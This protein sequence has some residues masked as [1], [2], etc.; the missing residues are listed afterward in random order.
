MKKYKGALLTVGIVASVICLILFVFPKLGMIANSD[1]ISGIAAIN[2]FNRTMESWAAVPNGGREF[3]FPFILSIGFLV[4]VNNFLNLPIANAGLILVALFLTWFVAYKI[5]MYILKVK[6]NVYAKTA[7]F[8]LVSYVVSSGS[9]RIF[10]VCVTT[11]LWGTLF[12]VMSIYFYLRTLEEKRFSFLIILQ[13]AFLD[14]PSAILAVIFMVFYGLVGFIS[15]LV[16][17]DYQRAKHIVVTLLLYGL[18]GAMINSYWIIN[19]AYATFKGTDLVSKFAENPKETTSILRVINS[20]NNLAFNFIL[21]RENFFTQEM[22][23]KAFFPVELFLSFGLAFLV[24]L[25]VYLLKTEKDKNLRAK[26]LWFAILLMVFISLAFG[27]KDL[28]GIFNF[29]WEYVPGFIVFRDF[30]KFHRLLQIIYVLLGSYSLVRILEKLKKPW[31]KAGLVGVSALMLLAFIP[32]KFLYP[33]YKPFTVPRYYDDFGD[34][35]AETRLNDHITIF[36]IITWHQTFDWSNQNYDMGDPIALVSPKPIFMNFGSYYLDYVQK[37]NLETAEYLSSGNSD[38][39]YRLLA[40]RGIRYFIIRSDHQQKYLQNRAEYT[41]FDKFLNYKKFMWAADRLEYAKRIMDFGK[42][43]LYKMDAS[44]F[45]PQLYVPLTIVKSLQT[46][47]D[48]DLIFSSEKDGLPFRLAVLFEGQEENVNIDAEKVPEEVQ[49]PPILEYRKINHAKYRVRVHK[50][51]STFP[52]VLTQKY[53]EGW[54]VYLSDEVQKNNVSDFEDKYKILDYNEEDQASLSEVKDYIQNGW[55]TTLGDLAEKDVVHKK[56]VEYRKALDYIEKINIDFISKNF[57]GTI[58][59]DNLPTGPFYETWSKSPV[60]DPHNH[61]I[62]NSFSNLWIID[63]KV[64]CA[65]NNECTLN[66]DGSYD[67]ELIIEFRGQKFFYM[68]LFVYGIT[69]AFCVTYLVVDTSVNLLR[70]FRRR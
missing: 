59:N 41:E 44:K 52:L 60:V 35:Y 70:R 38:T 63:P 66:A 22:Y 30:Y 9:T 21:G 45:L 67:M 13:L 25:G 15:S 1:G 55:V 20:Y 57:N 49:S 58:Q 69:A 34:Y 23:D 37:I 47:D 29:L 27:P 62:V 3:T 14:L 28:F 50:A 4:F 16:T 39:F 19:N 65:S 6:D 5:V 61:F 8:L 10:M 48:M 40:V 31:Q 54:L 36:P 56:T 51:F 42:L 43:A 64:I 2:L 53:H 12:L 7:I 18:F 26:L 68:G 24:F 33:L 46:P 32:Y 17:K 11:V